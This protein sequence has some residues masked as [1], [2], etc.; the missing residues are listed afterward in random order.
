MQ[1]GE[2]TCVRIANILIGLS[3]ALSAGTAAAEPPNPEEHKSCANG[4]VMLMAKLYEE[5]A[6]QLLLCADV[7][8]Q[9]TY[10]TARALLDRITALEKLDRTAEIE[11]TLLRL[12]SPPLSTAREFS[13][14]PDGLGF[15][16]IALGGARS[17]K[18]TQAR[19]LAMRAGY[20]AAA[21]DRVTAIG[22]A[23]AAL[24]SA[25][26]ENER[27][28][29]SVIEAEAEAYA[30]RAKM[31]FVLKMGEMAAADVVRA[32][33]RGSTDEWIVAQANTFPPEIVTELG[34]M[35]K[36][37]L[38]AYGVVTVNST[39]YAA[40]IMDR[41]D[42]EPKIADGLAKIAAVKA[43]EDELV[44]PMQWHNKAE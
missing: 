10:M 28:G 12:T 19:L 20:R 43:R 23:E 21:D 8:G 17:V 22:L 16:A 11:A 27:P 30:T 18:V 42:R 2:G 14:Q 36:K 40:L 33:V 4:D 25:A 15:G 7:P 29:S 1:S 37:M 5:A 9:T 3:I 44:G 38:E 35:R 32:Y 13:N 31:H 39:T 41:E 24:R 6:S 26:A 34:G